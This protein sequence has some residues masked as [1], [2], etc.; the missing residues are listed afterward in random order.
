MNVLHEC[1]NPICVNPAHLKEGTQSQNMIDAAR[2]QRMATGENAYN[3]KLKEAD[4]YEIRRLWPDWN[5]A[6]LARRFSVSSAVIRNVV[7]R[8]R[9]KWVKPPVGQLELLSI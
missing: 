2:R 1:D 8:T 5:C 9:W 7:M 3:A 6:D 4:V